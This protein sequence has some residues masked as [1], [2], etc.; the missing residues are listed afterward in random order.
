MSDQD[1]EEARAAL[2]ENQRKMAHTIGR[3]EATYGAL[4]RDE[5][6]IA[7]IVAETG[8]GRDRVVE[9]LQSIA[10]RELARL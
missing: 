6:L 3:L 4:P 10:Q 5:G 8:L 2:A 9:R 1:L 7:E